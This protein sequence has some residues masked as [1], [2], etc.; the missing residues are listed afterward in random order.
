MRTSLSQMTAVLA[1][2]LLY[3][4]SG[5]PHDPFPPPP[6][7]DK[8]T[9]TESP[10]QTVKT[11]VRYPPP[12]HTLAA[13]QMELQPHLR[14]TP[15]ECVERSAPTY[16]T[17]C[18]SIIASVTSSSCLSDSTVAANGRSVVTAWSLHAT[19]VLS[20]PWRPWTGRYC[21]QRLL[22]LRGEFHV[23][24]RPIVGR[25]KSSTSPRAE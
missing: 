6:P 2:F 9:P 22:N 11:T 5:A 24:A 4:G 19:L 23:S 10:K 15:R 3:T 18:S 13:Y 20:T 21:R 1:C 8:V 17:S 7:C 14:Q 16:L 12:V 25:R